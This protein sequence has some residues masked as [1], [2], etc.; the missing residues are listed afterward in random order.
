MVPRQDDKVIIS[1]VGGDIVG[2]TAE[3]ISFVLVPRLVSEFVVILLELNLPCGSAGSNFL[4][5]CPIHEV[6]VV[7][8]Y[9]DW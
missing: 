3:G 7:G 6:L 4:W 1:M 5:G 2:A 8:L 9:D